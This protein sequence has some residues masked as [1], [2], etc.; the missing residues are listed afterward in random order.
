MHLLNRRWFGRLSDGKP[1]LCFCTHDRH[2]RNHVHQTFTRTSAEVHRYPTKPTC[3][4]CS[5]SMVDSCKLLHAAELW[6]AAASYISIKA[7]FPA[8]ITSVTGSHI[9]GGSWQ[10]AISS[11]APPGYVKSGL[12]DPGAVRVTWVTLRDDERI[13]EG[14]PRDESQKLPCEHAIHAL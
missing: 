10:G 7:R 6:P 5:F 9:F 2:P 13:S 1:L 4:L 14:T 11:K 12:R 8:S 3:D